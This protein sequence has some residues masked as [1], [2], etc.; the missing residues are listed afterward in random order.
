MKIN[1][2][3]AHMLSAQNV[4]Q[5][6]IRRTEVRSRAGRLYWLEWRPQAQSHVICS[7]VNGVSFDVTT[8]PYNP[9][10][11]VHE[12]GGGAY[13]V[14][15]A[16]VVFVNAQDQAIYCQNRDAQGQPRLLL[17]RANC[18]YG[19]LV[20][21][22][23]HSRLLCVEEEHGIRVDNRLISIS[24][25]TGVR[26]VLAH[27]R[28]FY[29]AP[30]VN[31]NG[32]RLA[33]L[34]WDLPHMPWQECNLFE[35]RLDAHG[36]PLETHNLGLPGEAFAE[37]RYCPNG[38]LYCL[39]DRNGWWNIYCVMQGNLASMAPLKADVGGLSWRLGQ[40]HFDF[41]DA[42][43]LVFGYHHN[44][45]GELACLHVDSGLLQPLAPAS[46]WWRSIC[47]FH[48]R[49]AVLGDGVMASDRLL[50]ANA[51]TCVEV[52]LESTHKHSSSMTVA[53]H[54]SFACHDGGLGH[55]YFYPP[56]GPAAA[57]APLLVR[58]HGG[59]VSASTGAYNPETQYWS[60]R[61]YALVDVNYR[62]SSG[63]GTEYRQSLYQRWGDLD[64]RDCEAAALA[65][66]QEDC[67]DPDRIAIRGSSAGGLT[68]L[69]GWRHSS[70]FKAAT[71]L[72]GVTDLHSLARQT[73][74]YER[75]YLQW[76]VGD[77]VHQKEN[78]RNRSPVYENKPGKG[79]VML[80]Q[81]VLDKVVPVDQARRLHQRFRGLGRECEYIEF[82]DEGHG[83]S[84]TENR[85]LQLKA[86]YKF[87]Q[88][89]LQS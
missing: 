32:D 46:H 15:D 80:F 60:Q 57:R 8:K 16:D 12:Y 85:R 79:A 34:S 30:T 73:H 28:D 38:V 69:N 5:G 49:L 55:A 10:S 25:A 40:F 74:K 50:V 70:N 11:K 3:P 2:S 33:W 63:Y 82:A 35:A 41:L 19:D 29:A 54:F 86:E 78:Y 75:G 58:A 53:Q 44:G 43:R 31:E 18:R 27:G 77:L 20:F 4:A 51:G 9:A 6:S 26:Q 71:S 64:W 83:I 84:K 37:P 59:P 52:L 39:S 72:Y 24:L 14:T 17:A 45:Q 62:G 1:P 22:A 81:G 56:V 88:K 21:D 7:L 67:V 42:G 68:A 23:A 36:L 76:L 61:G 48:G 47:C 87:Y 89:V 66:V 13:C 65:L